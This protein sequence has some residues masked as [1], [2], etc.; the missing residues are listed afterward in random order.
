[1]APVKLVTRGYTGRLA[2]DPAGTL[3]QGETTL[4]TGGRSQTPQLRPLGRLQLD[5]PKAGCTFWYTQEY[6]PATS[7][8]SWHT[9]IGS[10]KCASCG[11]APA[12][13]LAIV[14]TAS[15]G[16]VR[17]SSLTYTLTVTNNGPDRT[18][19]VTVTD[20]LPGTVTFQS[21]DAVTGNLLGDGDGDLRARSSGANGATATVTIVVTPTVA[22]AIT[23]TASVGGG[24]TDPSPG[25]NSSSV[26]TTVAEPQ[27]GL[28]I[29]KTASARSVQAGTDLTYTITVTNNGPQGATGVIVTDPL[30][31]GTT[32]KSAS[33]SQGS[34]SG[35]D[36]VSC[37]LSSLAN[38]GTATVT[39]V[40]TT[41]A[42]EGAITN[43]ASVSG[44]ETDPNA[45]NNSASVTTTD[46]L[47][48][49]RGSDAAW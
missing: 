48:A 26:T 13:D 41:P 16:A 32:F 11:A 12:G 18:T 34:C 22:G 25:N 24:V 3:P 17:G 39:I 10:L 36:T 28:A 14:K 45:A 44:Y 43:T 46:F 7:S 4:I 49:P 21:G 5:G 8:A 29:G 35:T 9:R 33:A 40:I 6:Y 2:H 37:A 23:N 15:P 38:A 47:G 1:M 31:A 27:A 19:G 20:S 30:P 42:T